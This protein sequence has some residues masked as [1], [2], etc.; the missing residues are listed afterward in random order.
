MKRLFALV[1]ALLLT[2]ATSAIA[3]PEHSIVRQYVHFIHLVIDLKPPAIPM[4]EGIDITPKVVFYGS[5]VVVAPGY[6]VSAW[7]IFES[8]EQVPAEVRKST[9]FTISRGNKFQK[10]PFTIVA[11]DEEHDLV[12]IKGDFTCPC[13]PLANRAPEIDEPTYAVGFPSYDSHGV[14]MLTIGTYQ[15]LSSEDT[16]LIT[17]H[18]APGGSGGGGFQKEDGEFRLIGIINS[19]GSAAVGP[20]RFGF[21]QQLNWMTY[22]IPVEHIRALLKD[23][24]AEATVQ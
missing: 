17:A 23:T 16:H 20:E 12:L 11:K 18:T 10:L 8:A 14:Q 9:S 5:A 2:V 13:A 1:L 24:P 19:I 15:G 22:L 6:A 7:H 4:L 21:R 3:K